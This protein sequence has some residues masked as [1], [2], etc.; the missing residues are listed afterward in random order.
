MIGADITA[1][2]ADD[3]ACA[4][5][6]EK[7]HKNTKSM[8]IYRRMYTKP[9]EIPRQEPGTPLLTKVS[10]VLIIQH[11]HNFSHGMTTRSCKPRSK[12]GFPAVIAIFSELFPNK[13][14]MAWGWCTAGRSLHCCIVA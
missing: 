6:A 14:R 8:D 9:S 13:R 10:A 2:E 11:S 12:V 5:R 4:G 7:V 3:K 1:G